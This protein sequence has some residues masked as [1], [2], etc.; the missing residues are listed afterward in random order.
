MKWLYWNFQFSQWS[1]ETHNLK[2]QSRINLLWLDTY[3]S[4][5]SLRD[6]ILIKTTVKSS[7]CRHYCDGK[8]TDWMVAMAG[9]WCGVC[10]GG[11]GGDFIKLIG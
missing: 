3:L 11:C 6:D 8:A 5:T 1:L 4:L 10:G 2:I 9:G 7:G